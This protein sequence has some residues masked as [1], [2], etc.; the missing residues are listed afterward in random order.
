MH[1]TGRDGARREGQGSDTCQG[2]SGASAL[3]YQLLSA[4]LLAALS[5]SLSCSQLLLV[6]ISCSLSCSQLLS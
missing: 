2:S 5:S 3:C 1:E 6:A 4:P